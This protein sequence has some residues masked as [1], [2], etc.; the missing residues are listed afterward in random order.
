MAG[1]TDRPS[2]RRAVAVGDGDVVEYPADIVEQALRR[3]AEPMRT[4]LTEER[5]VASTS[6]VSFVTSA[7]IVGTEVSQVQRNFSIALT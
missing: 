2:F 6:V 7:I 3:W 5:S 1:E 4:I